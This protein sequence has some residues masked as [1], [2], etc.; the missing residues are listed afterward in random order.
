MNLFHNLVAAIKKSYTNYINDKRF[1]DYRYHSNQFMVRIPDDQIDDLYGKHIYEDISRSGPRL[2]REIYANV[3]NW[4]EKVKGKVEIPY[5][6]DVE[7]C[8]PVFYFSREEVAQEFRAKFL[9]EV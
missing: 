1:K 7:H 9:K 5:V 2:V 3:S 8:V 6:F 4:C